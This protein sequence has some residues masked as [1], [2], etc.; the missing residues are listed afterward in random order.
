LARAQVRLRAIGVPAELIQEGRLLS[1]KAPAPGSIIDLQVS[2]GAYLNDPTAAIMTIANLDTVWVTANEPEK[3]IALVTTGQSVELMFTA[4][5]D[6]VLKGRVLFV[7]DVL[8]QDTR[9]TKVGIAIANPDMR[10]KPNMFANVVFVAP[11]RMMPVVPT[12]ALV[13]R[14]EIDQ[15]FVEVAPWTFEARPVEVAFREGA[16]EVIGRGLDAGE[17]VVVEGGVLLND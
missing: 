8:A 17:R 13:L 16:Q 3:D 1:L 14:N 6:E 15:V 11:A 7:S 2:R 10:F 9:R 4:Y 5:P 12:T